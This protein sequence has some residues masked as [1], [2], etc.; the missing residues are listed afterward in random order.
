[1]WKRERGRDQLLSSNAVHLERVSDRRPDE[2][3]GFCWLPA[4]SFPN[5]LPAQRRAFLNVLRCVLPEDFGKMSGMQSVCRTN[6]T[7]VVTAERVT[8][9]HIFHHK[10]RSAKDA[11][12]DLMSGGA[13]VDPAQGTLRGP[14]RLH[15]SLEFLW[16][17]REGTVWT[18]I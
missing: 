1:M 14:N 9:P 18:S 8:L 7:H 17:Q 12:T 3:A 2:S 13:K 5:Q 15:H 11:A 10:Q 4:E 6:R 16:L